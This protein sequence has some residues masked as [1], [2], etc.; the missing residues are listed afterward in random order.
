MVR[1]LVKSLL[2]RLSSI[3]ALVAQRDRLLAERQQLLASL[4][5]EGEL[6]STAAPQAATAFQ[7]FGGEWVSNVPGFGMGALPLFDDPRVRW[8][9][10]QLCGFAGKRVLE[11]GSLEGGHSFMM[12]R[13]GTAQILAIEGNTRAFLR[14][15][16]VK[17]A[18][19]FD[20]DFLL[21]DFQQYLA[22]T[23]ERFDFVLACGVLYHL[24]RPV[25]LLEDMARVAPSLGIWTH[26]YDRDVIGR[27][28]ELRRRFA[29]EPTVQQFRGRPIVGFEQRYIDRLSPLAG[30]SPVSLW[31]TKESLLSVL[32]A[33]D[34]KVVIGEAASGHPAGPAVLLYATKR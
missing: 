14:S 15:L 26:Y 23:T 13:A 25:R 27:R 16:I 30:D 20:A 34:L 18:I 33:L 3:A 32:D 2:S 1:R 6:H 12:A 11:L 29:H 21:G 4:Y 9:G 17:N 7:Q 24:T 8:L 5:R 19:K 31:L 22:V 28:P 10:E